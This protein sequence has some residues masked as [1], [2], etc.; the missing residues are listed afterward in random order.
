M[1]D[2]NSTPRRKIFNLLSI[3]IGFLCVEEAYA[4]LL[5]SGYLHIT[6]LRV[7]ALSRCLPNG[8]EGLDQSDEHQG[9]N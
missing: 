3:T 1:K 7:L 4:D 9:R 8:A 6:Y 2:A 5:R